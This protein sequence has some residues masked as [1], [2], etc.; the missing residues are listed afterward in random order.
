MVS[1][2]TGSNKQLFRGQLPEFHAYI[3]EQSIDALRVGPQRFDCGIG[4][5]PEK[6]ASLPLDRVC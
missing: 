4:K 3:P 1:N 2:P 5:L 6:T